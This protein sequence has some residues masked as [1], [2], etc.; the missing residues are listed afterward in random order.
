MENKVSISIFFGVVVVR[1]LHFANSAL[2]RECVVFY[3]H[4]L[5]VAHIVLK[6]A[7][8]VQ[9]YSRR[10]SVAS[11]ACYRDMLLNLRNDVKRF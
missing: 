7:A 1:F 4:V 6:Y 3:V 5:C 9:N 10:A 8:G 2:F 11:D